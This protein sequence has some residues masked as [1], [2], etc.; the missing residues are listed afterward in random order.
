MNPNAGSDGDDP[1]EVE[2]RAALPA[3]SICNLTE[4]TDLD[5]LFTGEDVVAIGAA[6]GDGTLSAVARIAADLR[7]PFVVVPAGTLNHL[8]RDLG[9]DSV[10]DAVH[11]IQAGTALCMDLGVAND[12][13]FVNTLTLGGYASVV[14]ARERLE[15]RAGKWP[16]L[17]VALVREL[18]RME[19]LM[20]E[21]DGVTMRIWLAWVGNCRY[22]PPGLA[23]LCRED[24]ADGLLDVRIVSGA[25][26]FSRT[27]FVLSVLTGTLSSSRVYEERLVESLDIR[28]L[29][30]A[31]EAATDGETFVAPA[32]LR[33]TKRRSA[34]T[35]AAPPE[36][37]AG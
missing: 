34:L 28:S 4:G 5:G 27:R 19:P 35:V 26:R 36:P 18:P 32:H 17:A 9:I 23:P 2:L 6:G 16:A 29:N 14:I 24:L 31:L 11:A 3:V 8:A 37:K 21:V 7:L 25:H 20:L 33:I 10:E 1:P 22:G 15:G 30:G 12:R 13:T